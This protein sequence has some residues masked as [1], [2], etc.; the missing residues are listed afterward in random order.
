MNE[1]NLYEEAYRII[2]E[3][4]KELYAADI[5]MSCEDLRQYLNSELPAD[6]QYGN[7]RRVFRAAWDRADDESKEALENSFVDKD[8]KPLL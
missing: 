2:I 1:Q 4:A 5:K 3:K 7:L 8:G 6:F